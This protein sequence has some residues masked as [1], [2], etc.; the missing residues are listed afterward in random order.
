M[1]EPHVITGFSMAER[2]LI[3]PAMISIQ[4]SG[5]ALHLLAVQPVVRME[6]GF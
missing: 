4:A 1:A 2:A 6:R 3:K 5:P